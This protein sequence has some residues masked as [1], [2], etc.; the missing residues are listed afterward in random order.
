MEFFKAES[1]FKRGYNSGMV[2]SNHPA[3]LPNDTKLI[4]VYISK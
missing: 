2:G 3:T 1:F 4:H